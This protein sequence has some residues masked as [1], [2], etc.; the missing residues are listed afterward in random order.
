MKKFQKML[1]ILLLIVVAG[2]FTACAAKE[3][4]TEEKKVI[5]LGI[6]GSDNEVWAHIKE[7]LAKEDITLEVISFS[8][9]TRPNVALADGEIDINS[10]QHYAFFENFKTE[11]S[12]D[13]TAIGETV[14]API[15]LYSSK[16]QDVSELKEGDEI[17]I[18]NDA[19]N[20]GRALIL[21]Q[22]AGLIKLDEAAGNLPTLKDITENKLNLKITEMDAGTTAR[23]L[24]DVA[25]AA[26][27]SGFAVDAGFTPTKDSIFLEPIDENSKPYINIIVARTEDKDN[28][29]Y[30][31]VVELYQTEE[32]RKIVDEIYKGSQV[33]TW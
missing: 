22:T 10:F 18:P 12:L 25:A 23:T 6:T 20:G 33:T 19:T 2:T 15:G 14:I 21:L 4:K 16:I 28:E 1:T 8:D 26:I 13:L 29:L 17:T 24:D 27:N 11:H 5:K 31:K 32:V 30:K 9:Y 7:E 3:T